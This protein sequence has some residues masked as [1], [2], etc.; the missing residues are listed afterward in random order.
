VVKRPFTSSRATWFPTSGGY[1]P[2]L[3]IDALVWRAAERIARRDGH[4]A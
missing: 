4:P 2:M 1:N 3:T